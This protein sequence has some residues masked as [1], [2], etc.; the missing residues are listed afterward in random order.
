MKVMWVC[1][2]PNNIAINHTSKKSAIYG[3]WLSGLSQELSKCNDS[4]QLVYC[5]P[6][7]GKKEQDDFII[8]NVHYYSFYA[9]K[10]LGI[11]N[12][13][14]NK[15]NWITR[16]DIKKIID[17][18][19][20]D[21]LHIFG[22]E[23][24]HALI[25]AQ[26]FEHKDRIV[27]S[28]QGLVSVISNHFLNYIPKHLFHKVN[29]SSIFRKTLW[30]QKK[31]LKKRG[32]KEVETLNICNNVIGRTEWDKACTYYINPKRLYY[33]CNETLRNS[34]YNFKWEYDKCHRYTIFFSQGSSPIKG[35]NIMVEALALLKKEFPN[36]SLRIAGNNFV[37]KNSLNDK[38]KISTYGDY[39]LSLIDKHRLSDKILFLGNLSEDEMIKEYLK[40]NVFV[41]ASS[42]ENSSNSV[43]EAMLLGV[44][45][46]SSDVGGISSLV[47]D[48]IEALLYP[49]YDSYMLAWRI[50]E[51]FNNKNKAIKLGNNARS[52]AKVT[53]DKKINN[54]QLINIYNHILGD[55]EYS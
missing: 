37:S 45:I 31:D 14:A 39:I 27:C 43:C 19:K 35:L 15:D 10:K 42:I 7:L 4:V 55:K 36:I 30:G 8:D 48:N 5:Y 32:V 18:E 16:R 28:I 12:V 11:I 9:C 26:E 23:Y 2:Q 20:P 21:I 17:I 44:P 46:V 1:N 54:Q 49:G 3:G 33:H 25:S 50:K 51:I 34:F 47:T 24:T 22:T 6:R 38:I 41:S 53:H 13:N 40:C 29:F 52:R